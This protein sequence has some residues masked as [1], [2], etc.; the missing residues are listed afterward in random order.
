MKVLL[1][2]AA[3]TL[4]APSL[5]QTPTAPKPP[6]TPIKHTKTDRHGSVIYDRLGR[7]VPTTPAPKDRAGPG[8]G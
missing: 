3:L 4:A 1:L 8:T 2:I 6:T 5:A 7:Q